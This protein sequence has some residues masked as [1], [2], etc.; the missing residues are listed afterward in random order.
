MSFNTWNRTRKWTH[1][2]GPMYLGMDFVIFNEFIEYHYSLPNFVHVNNLILQ[3][4]T[5]FPMGEMI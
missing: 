1:I 5:L 2:I 3:K 4:L